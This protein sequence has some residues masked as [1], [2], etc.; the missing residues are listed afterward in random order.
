MAGT[1]VI[2]TLKSSTTGPAVFQNTN[3]TEVGQLCRAWVNFNGVTAAIRAAFNVSSVVRNAVGDYTINFTN[4]MPDAS[5]AVAGASQTVTGNVAVMTG[6]I[7]ATDFAKT[8][9]SFRI[10]VFNS[11]TGTSIDVNSTNVCVFR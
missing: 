8:T 3:G 4:T 10:N 9:S 6:Y 1:L 2:D 7:N 5:Y 11:S